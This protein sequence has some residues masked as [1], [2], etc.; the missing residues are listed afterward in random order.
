MV[1][2]MSDPISRAMADLAHK[3]Q[4][5]SRLQTEAEKL[6]VFIEM[7]RSYAD[8]PA[9]NGSEHGTPR[10]KKDMSGDAAI[11]VI[12]R[13]KVPVPFGSLYKEI[14]ASGVEVGTAKPK[15]YLS[16][17]LNRDS[18]FRSIKGEGWVLAD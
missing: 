5:I 9:R 8:V 4:E 7:Y 1:I 12:K 17:T 3:E 10:S 16:T 11:E 13:H 2:P 14:E 6:R 18:R 15:Q